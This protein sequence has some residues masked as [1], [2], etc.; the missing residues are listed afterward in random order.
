MANASAMTPERRRELDE[1]N[2]MAVVAKLISAAASLPPGLISGLPAAPPPVMREGKAAAGPHAEVKLPP[3]VC[4]P[5]KKKSRLPEP[6]ADGNCDA[7]VCTIEYWMCSLH[8][9][10][11]EPIE[12]TRV[13]LQS[14]WKA[15]KT[16]ERHLANTRGVPYVHKK[17]ALGS[18][19]LFWRTGKPHHRQV[20]ERQKWSVIETAWQTYW[21]GEAVEFPE[22][23]TPAI[24]AGKSIEEIAGE[25]DLL[26]KEWTTRP[27]ATMEH[28]R[29]KLLNG[30]ALSYTVFVMSR[31][32]E[33]VRIAAPPEMP[34]EIDV[35]KLG[36]SVSVPGARVL[37]DNPV[38]REVARSVTNTT[39]S[40]LFRDWVP[41]CARTF[42]NLA[43]AYQVLE[44]HPVIDSSPPAGDPDFT[45]FQMKLWGF[46]SG[47]IVLVPS[48][49]IRRKIESISHEIVLPLGAMDYH[50][51]D[52]M[53]PAAVPSEIFQSEYGIKV[54]EQYGKALGLPAKTIVGSEYKG[55]E[56]AGLKAGLWLVQYHHWMAQRV[57]GVSFLDRFVVLNSQLRERCEMIYKWERR[58]SRARSPLIVQIG[59]VFYVNH[60]RKMMRSDHMFHA[61]SLWSW[62]VHKQMSNQLDT[63]HDIYARW[64][65]DITESTR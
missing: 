8:L 1:M 13:M 30:L 41:Q 29:H 63:G 19:V 24:C 43:L 40:L 31:G 22:Q 61:L 21:Y 27:G 57:D 37:D 59:T 34:G 55:I 44:W 51:R 26:R 42:L 60:N 47:K 17:I 38:T 7:D 5:V 50:S 4:A 10:A 52:E 9:I 15:F 65:K 49:D 35:E 53:A 58:D 20:T 25:L 23:C 46:F 3:I 54:A 18:M 56:G 45:N 48:E 39:R 36:A 32:L 14:L 33:G 11:R 64:F 6:P 12:D 28:E 62:I 16:Y 2:S